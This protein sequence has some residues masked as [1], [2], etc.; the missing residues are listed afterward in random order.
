VKSDHEL[1]L[2]PRATANDDHAVVVAWAKDDGEQVA[3]DDVICELEFS[4]SVVELPAP[5]EGWLYHLHKVG[6]EVSVGTPLAAISSRAERP[7]LPSARQAS[8]IKVTA[9]ARKLIEAHG[10]DV[11]VFQ[12]VDIVKEKHVRAFVEAQGPAVDESAARGELTAPTPVRRRAAQALTESK[13]TIPHSHLCRWVLAERVDTH[14]EG[15]AQRHD[16]MVS[17]ADWLV[18]TVARQAGQNRKVNASWRPN[19]IFVHSNLNVGYALNQSNG[20]LLVPVVVDADRLELDELVGRLRG[21]QKKAHR[22]R[23]TPEELSGG[24]IT[25]TSLIGSGVHQVFPILVPGQAVIVAI[26]DRCDIGDTA[27]YNL[28]VAFDHRVLN[29]SESAEFLSAVAKGLEGEE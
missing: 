2:V 5:S 9:K 1:V 23:L 16:M 13:Q 19:G 24:T 11:G 25:V 3:K 20:D 26:G 4:K 27:T 15:L 12:G 17:V 29:G 22:H 10:L 8:G 28:T 7:V 6:D 18:A 21:L 14:V